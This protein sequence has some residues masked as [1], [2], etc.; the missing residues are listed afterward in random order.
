MAGT[1]N[2]ARPNAGQA[3]KRTTDSQSAAGAK[4]ALDTKTVMGR[5]TARRNESVRSEPLVVG[6]FDD[7]D[8][9]AFEH[10]PDLGVDS[11]DDPWEEDGEWDRP[12]GGR[13]PAEITLW[14]SGA[15]VEFSVREISLDALGDPLI[16]EHALKRSR[17]LVAYTR[18]LVAQ[19]ARADLDGGLKRLWDSMPA[20]S[21]SKFTA[22]LEASRDE[23]GEKLGADTVSRDRDVLV[24]LPGCTIAL[25]FLLSKTDNDA[26][27]KMIGRVIREDPTLSRAEVDRRV[28]GAGLGSRKAELYLGWIQLA[29]GH[30]TVTAQYAAALRATPER[31]DALLDAY[32]EHLQSANSFSAPG[33]Q[34]YAEYPNRHHAPLTRALVG[35]DR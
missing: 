21:Q 34:M 17:R 22:G 24:A 20:V 3:A 35:R 19:L 2:K 18:V 26:T 8:M 25:G 33:R 5:G 32:A 16:A 14:R 4:G 27:V 28:A 1:G 12:R 11:S 29:L 31:Y 13:P 9:H 10:E 23:V 30:P 15:N 7:D 6:R